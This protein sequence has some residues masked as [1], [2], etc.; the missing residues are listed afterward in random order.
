MVVSAFNH[1]DKTIRG[2]FAFRIV[3][4]RYEIYPLCSCPPT[5]FPCSGPDYFV[6]PPFCELVLQ[7]YLL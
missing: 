6:F 4:R 2:L 1:S 5:E 3:I 7:L